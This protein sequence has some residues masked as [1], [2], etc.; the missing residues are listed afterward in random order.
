MTIKTRSSQSKQV[1]RLLRTMR[2]GLGVSVADL[3]QRA[4]ISREKLHKW[5]QFQRKLTLRELYR[6]ADAL[7][8]AVMDRTENAPRGDVSSASGGAELKEIRGAYGITQI[9]L[10]REM[11]MP[12]VSISLFENGYVKFTDRE[13]ARLK[14]VMDKLKKKHEI[15]AQELRLFRDV[16]ASLRREIADLNE[17]LKEKGRTGY[18]DAGRA[19]WY[20]KLGQLR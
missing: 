20:G 11:G 8:V 4:N 6:L 7:D 19:K 18:F 9:E 17:Q 13:L 10:A 1:R 2:E 14:S 15:T 3:A 5:E 16:E 12:Q